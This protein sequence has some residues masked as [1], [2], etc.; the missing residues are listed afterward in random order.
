LHD[1]RSALDAALS[2]GGTVI[3]VFVIDP[4]MWS[5]KW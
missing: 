4:V 3:P 5:G 1:N 2:Q